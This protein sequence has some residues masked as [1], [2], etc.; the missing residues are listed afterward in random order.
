MPEHFNTSNL[1][2]ISKRFWLWV[3]TSQDEIL[4]VKRTEIIKDKTNWDW[5][6]EDMRGNYFTVT[7]TGW[8]YP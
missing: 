2:P 8:A 5:P 4:R 6:V 3:K 1:P 7:V